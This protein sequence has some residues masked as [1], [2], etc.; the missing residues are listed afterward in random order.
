MKALTGFGG[1]RA[2]FDLMAEYAGRIAL[3]VQTASPCALGELLRACDGLAQGEELEDATLPAETLER[4]DAA[5]WLLRSG[6]AEKAP[7]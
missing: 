5:A 6:I 1:S 2:Y 7:F 3:S 4:A